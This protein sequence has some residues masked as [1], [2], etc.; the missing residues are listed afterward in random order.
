[1]KHLVNQMWARWNELLTHMRRELKITMMWLANQM[2]TRQ[3]DLLTQ[4]RRV[5]KVTMIL[6]LWGG[7]YNNH[8]EFCL[9][10]LVINWL[11]KKFFLTTCYNLCVLYIKTVVTCIAA[12]SLMLNSNIF[13]FQLLSQS[14]VEM[15]TLCYCDFSSKCD[16]VHSI[17]FVQYMSRLCF[18]YSVK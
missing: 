13:M 3:M 11:S 16:K 12:K 1:M 5:Q 15:Y 8:L 14:P 4:T 6:V 17:L 10:M 7:G 2:W 9:E 18:H